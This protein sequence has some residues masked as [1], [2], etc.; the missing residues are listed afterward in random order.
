MKVILTGAAGMLGTS[1]TA[2]WTRLRPGDELI[3]VD[4]TEIDLRDRAA[5]QELVLAAAPDAIIHVAAK[6]GGIGDRLARPAEYLLDNLLIDTAVVSAALAAEVP[7]LLYVSSAGIYPAEAD[8]PIMEDALLTGPLEPAL[9][10]YAIAKIA[11]SRLCSY[12]S[13]ERGYRYRVMVPS[14]MYGAGE[15]PALD[16]AQLVTAALRKMYDARATGARAVEVWGDGSA[17]RELTYVGD[18][19]EWVAREVGHLERWP[20]M[21]NLGSGAEATV[22][23]VYETART[24]S[25]VDVQLNFDASKPVGVARRVLNSQRAAALG[26]SAST[27]LA[28]GMALAWSALCERLDGESGAAAR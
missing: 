15:D 16:R 3:G 14:N 23:E 19:A 7:E 6:V 11:G 1:V 12:A 22:A 27:G 24:V 8:Q 25:G 9:E 26:W 5:V 20:V 21:I 28:D 13:A 2:A 18:V 17:R 4:R 10:P